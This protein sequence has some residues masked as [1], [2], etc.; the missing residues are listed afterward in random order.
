MK[1]RKLQYHQKKKEVSLNL[2]QHPVASTLGY[3]TSES[4]HVYMQ[5]ARYC[6]LMM[7]DYL[8]ISHIFQVLTTNSLF[9][10][11]VPISVRN[12]RITNKP[13]RQRK[14]KSCYSS[15]FLTFTFR[16]SQLTP[17]T[18]QFS[19]DRQSLIEKELPYSSDNVLRGP[20]PKKRPMISG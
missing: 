3:S 16:I 9:F 18:I 7:T 6:S 15:Q 17:P 8:Q 12:V 13:I 14:N 2:R 1:K 20:A 19:L 5:V 10:K 11:G 4:F